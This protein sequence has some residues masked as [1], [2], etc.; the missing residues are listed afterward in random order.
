[1]QP[2]EEEP[3]YGFEPNNTPEEDTLVLF[4]FTDDVLFKVI[5]QLFSILGMLLH[6]VVLQHLPEH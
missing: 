5:L 4:G 6:A 1:M 2:L 3:D